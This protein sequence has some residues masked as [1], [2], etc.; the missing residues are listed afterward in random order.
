M[1]LFLQATA[2]VL[3]SVVIVLVLN[4]HSKELALLLTLGVCCMVIAA[5]G[6]FIQPV[7]G[8]L[9]NLQQIGQLDSGYL[10]V[11][12][13][14]VGI[15]FLSEV[16]ALVCADAGNATL[17]KTLQLLGSCVVLWLSIPLLNSLLELIQD[18]LG[19]I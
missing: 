9:D 7:V 1:E 11:L 19:E 16:A 2:A 13:K 12:L 4:P 3:V 18:I 17:G 15:G 8:F 5:A 10:S 14:I 6:Q